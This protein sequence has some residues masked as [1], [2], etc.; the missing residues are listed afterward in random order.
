MNRLY[1]NLIKV[2][3]L[4]I[5]LVFC[6][7]VR[8]C[9]PTHD[10]LNI[11][12]CTS[13]QS[14]SGKYTWTVSDTYRD[15]L[16]NVSGCDSL[17]LIHLSVNPPP[18]PQIDVSV[19]DDNLASYSPPPYLFCEDRA[20]I[21]LAANLHGG[22]WSCPYPGVITGD[23]FKPGIAPANTPFFITYLYTDANGCKGADSTQVEIEAKPT[24]SLS[25]T[26][27]T[28][29]RS[30]TMSVDLIP[31]FTNAK[32][33][34]W[35]PFTGGSVRPI[36]G[37]AVTFSFSAANDTS[38]IHVLV[39]RINSGTACTYTEARF[40]A[41][42]HPVPDANII[43]DI[44][45]GCQPHIAAL[46]TSFNNKVDPQTSSYE[47]NFGDG[48]TAFKQNP[49]YLFDQVGVNNVSLT[50]T[51]E[52]GCDTTLT[53]PITVHPIPIA[54]FEP[55]PNNSAP[56]S[57]PTFKFQNASAITSGTIVSNSWDFGDINSSTDVSTE[58]SPS[59]T[60]PNE[61]ASYI[62]ALRVVSEFGCRD[63]FMNNVHVGTTSA[64]QNPNNPS[65][66][67]IAPN[68]A[69][70]YCTVQ[71]SRGNRA[72]ITVYSLTAKKLLSIESQED[73]VDLPLFQLNKGMYLV[74]V[75]IGQ[76]RAFQRLVLN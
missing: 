24:I 53:M 40:I 23:T 5:L 74:E 48:G 27:T 32:S 67:T 19:L 2:L 16:V 63:F 68:P 71:L 7:E 20:D 37:N 11:K 66:F 36:S 56:I 76:E 65:L 39:V 49:T 42:I 15:T 14:P 44:D 59:Y 17:L 72:T 10:T 21:S 1:V 55:S 43:P 30:N 9:T 46:S 26:D 52:H 6:R 61:K 28:L 41:R 34:D 4:G 57:Q 12:A 58:T 64:A 50:I 70:G 60:Y 45:N 22:V 35:I 73:R 38:K 69:K 75:K 25:R 31:T 13:Y 18:K 29:C 3:V 33:I 51:S 54:Y 62:V 47:W 8:A